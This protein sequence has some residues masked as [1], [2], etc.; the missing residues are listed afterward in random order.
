M[1]LE[2]QDQ[3]HARQPAPLPRADQPAEPGEEAV[4]HPPA[5][6]DIFGDP[7]ITHGP[8]TFISDTHSISGY[9]ARPAAEGRYPAVVIL[10]GNAGLPEDIRYYAALL[11]RAGFAGLV[12]DGFSRDP[13]PT[14]LDRDFLFSF[15]LIK[16]IMHDAQAGIDWLKTKP[17]VAPGGVG[18]LG[19]C[20]GGVTSLMF[21]TVSPDVAAVVALYAAPFTSYVPPVDPRPDL[22]SF[23]ERFAAPI[24]YHYGTED[25]YIPTDDVARFT[26]SLRRNKVNAEVFVYEGAGHGFCNYASDADVYDAEAAALVQ[27]RLLD[28]LKAHLVSKS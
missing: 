18:M 12:I 19:I 7:T 16:R 21:S 9:L 26:D 10:H 3:E 24:Q 6:D 11:A 14:S 23:V 8:T 17:Y 1:C 5:P 20:G 27:R 4:Q 2:C 25:V 13:D 15:R 28:F 22:I